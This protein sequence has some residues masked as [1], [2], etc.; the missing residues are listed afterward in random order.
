MHALP[1]SPEDPFAEPPER[2]RPFWRWLP[3][4]A[5][6][7]VFEMT[8]NP[9]LG[10]A[11]A[12]FRFG[13]KDFRTAWWLGRR[14]P[15]RARGRAC[16]WFHLSWGFARIGMMSFL[17]TG[18]TA[19]LILLLDAVLK[20]RAMGLLIQIQG[21]LITA[22]GAIIGFL[23][24][25]YV[26]ITSALIGRVKVW[27]SPTSHRAREARRWPPVPEVAPAPESNR[28]MA[29]VAFSGISSLL[30]L[31]LV[32]AF[33]PGKWA[34]LQLFLNIAAGGMMFGLIGNLWLLI[35]LSPKLASRGPAECWSDTT[36]LEPSAA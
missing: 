20:F 31:F 4:I 33:I 6:L 30:C 32:P 16:A 7:M 5:G 24:A 22:L 10:V 12:C 13:E 3:L 26:A 9:M 21:A 25:S 36:S 14:D 23:L 17:A 15:N 27:V 18:L 11:L 29:V 2:A 8:Q 34:N 19:M 1:E 35:R 28:V